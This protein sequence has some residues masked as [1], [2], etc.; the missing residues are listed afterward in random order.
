MTT[1][2]KHTLLH[3][4]S[5]IRKPKYLLGRTKT[6]R[7]QPVHFQGQW[8]LQF[9]KGKGL[10]DLHLRTEMQYTTLKQALSIFFA[11]SAKQKEQTKI[12][13]SS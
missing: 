13:Y 4:Q 6:N 10:S 2:S 1:T 5:N 8:R 11:L 9:T 12:F 7:P 3:H